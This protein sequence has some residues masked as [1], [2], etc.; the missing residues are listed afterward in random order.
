M[1]LAFGWVESRKHL[2]EPDEKSLFTEGGGARYQILRWSK[3]GATLMKWH[4][5]TP[6]P[7]RDMA[8]RD[9]LRLLRDIVRNRS[10]RFGS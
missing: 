7:E 2:P 10:R 3:D 5:V 9:R 8:Y 1:A 4:L 6:T